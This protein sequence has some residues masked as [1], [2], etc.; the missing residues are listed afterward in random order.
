MNHILDTPRGPNNNLRPSLKSGHVVTN[1]RA[2]N[3][4][5]T[6]DG[7]EITNGDNDLLNLLGQLACR[8]KNQCLACLEIGVKF[9]KDRDGE[10]SGLSGSRLRLGNDI[11]TWKERSAP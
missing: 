6:V 1:T 11:G 4:G 8:C 5:M 7:H 10:G 9:L 2:S 3:A